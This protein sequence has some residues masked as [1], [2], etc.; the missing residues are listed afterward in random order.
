M[1]TG[2]S[3]AALALSPQVPAQDLVQLDDM[4]VTATR[5]ETDPQ[6]VGSAISVVTADDLETAKVGTVLEA[7]R[8]LP[9]IDVVQTGGPGKGAS[10][11]IRGHNSAHTKVL[12]DGVRLNGP[13]VGTYDFASLD[14]ANIERI[15]VVRGPQSALYGSDA[16]G[17]VINIITRRGQPGLHGSVKAAAGTS[18]SGN[19]ALSLSGGNERADFSASLS[20]QQFEG[21]SAVHGGG[22]RFDEDDDWVNKTFSGR[23]GL[24]FLEDGRADLALRIVKDKTD[25]DSFVWGAPVDDPNF[26]KDMDGVYTS[27]KAVKPLTEWFT[28]S[29]NFGVNKERTVWTDPDTAG[30]PADIKARNTDFGLQS[31]FFPFDNDTLTLGYDF[32]RQDGFSGGNFD[33]SVDLTAFFI[34]NQW[35]HGERLSV[36]AGCRND[37]HSAF[38]SRTTYRFA[39]AYLFPDWGTRLHGS[40]GTGFRAPTLNDLY[41]PTDAWGSRGNPNLKSEKSRSFDLG[42][43]Q[44]FREEQVVLDVTYFESRVEDLI[45]WAATGPNWWDPWTPQNVA[46]AKIRGLESTLSVQVREDLRVEASHTYTSAKDENTR[47]RLARRPNNRFGF[48]LHYDPTAELNVN[49]SLVR[50]STRYDDA[51]NNNTLAPYTRVDLAAS[52]DVTENFEVFGRVENLFNE[53]YREGHNFGITER[54]VL[55]GAK[56]SF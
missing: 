30:N 15:E 29:A 2:A 21:V 5:T 26:T 48:K 45:Q 56:V 49:L 50:V 18:R 31:D 43:E 9:G 22:G 13:T 38:G 32:E 39:G 55:G 40:W 47:D 8:T 44:G 19:G 1:V 16:I 3:I 11:F 28:Q 53:D 27:L 52:Y 35:S 10:V 20:M 17:G 46:K 54:Y 25:Q 42:I 6:L 24:N 37:R 33:E 41:W 23:F 36:T 4:V 14:V 12:L 51:A 7:L 34:Q